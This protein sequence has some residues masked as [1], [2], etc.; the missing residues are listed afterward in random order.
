MLADKVLIMFYFSY[1]LMLRCWEENPSHRPSF[2][3]ILH[4]FE[5]MFAV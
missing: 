2:T 5:E 1:N 4:E 3:D